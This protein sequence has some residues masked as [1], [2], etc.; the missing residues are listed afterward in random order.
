[1]PTAATPKTMAAAPRAERPSLANSTMATLV[2]AQESAAQTESDTSPTSAIATAGGEVTNSDVDQLLNAK[3]AEIFGAAISSLRTPL[4][5]LST[6]HEQLLA[7][8]TRTPAEEKEATAL[9]NALTEREG[10]AFGHFA[11]EAS[12]AATPQERAR[13]M[14]QYIKAYTEYYDSLSPEEQN[15]DRY[16]GTRE[17]LVAQYASWAAE[18]KEP[19]EDLSESRDPILMLFDKIRDAGFKVDDDKARSIL[20]EYKKGVASLLS[21]QADPE[22]AAATVNAASDR[23]ASVQA[24]INKAREGDSTAFGQLAALG[25]DQKTLDSFLAYATTLQR[26]P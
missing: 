1:M 24:V 8:T 7:K 25:D 22:T 6:R 10:K 20:E 5:D 17:G 18:A 23:F 16:R 19:A 15:S 13:L 3:G 14:T 9:G 26:V 12:A 21:T 11:K 2:Q 4:P